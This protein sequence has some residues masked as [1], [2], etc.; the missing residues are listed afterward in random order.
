MGYYDEFMNKLE[1]DLKLLSFLHEQGFFIKVNQNNTVLIRHCNN[2][3]IKSFGNANFAISIPVKVGGNIDFINDMIKALKN[4]VYKTNYGKEEM[5]YLYKE[6]LY[7][8]ELFNSKQI[9]EKA[10]PEAKQ[11]IK[12]VKI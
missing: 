11:T 7:F 3:Y 2:K 10:I 9:L 1:K 4:E 6:M 8:I 5:N 12:R